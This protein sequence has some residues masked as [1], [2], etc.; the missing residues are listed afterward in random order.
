[1]SI[2][3]QITG[4]RASG[5]TTT[6]EQLAGPN[7]LHLTRGELQQLMKKQLCLESGR[8][9]ILDGETLSGSEVLF[10]QAIIRAGKYEI[11]MAG[12]GTGSRPTPQVIVI[13]G[14]NLN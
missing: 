8:N 14:D 4:P 7:A 12:G 9:Y 11:N 10:L 5:K 3:I 1:M 2:L 6:A 13:D